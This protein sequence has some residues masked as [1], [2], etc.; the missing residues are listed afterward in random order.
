M[1]Q[2]VIICTG[3]RLRWT[4]DDGGRAQSRSRS[5]YSSYHRCR[6]SSPGAVSQTS[7]SY[8]GLIVILGCAHAGVINTIEY[9]RK[10]SGG[11]RI[12]AVLGGMHLLHASSRRLRL[13]VEALKTINPDF[14]G[15]A[16]CTGARATDELKAAFGKKCVDLNVGT[17]VSF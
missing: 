8:A 5:N 12:H 4:A 15:L 6:C 11:K 13:T 17:C 7:C 3:L 16:H 1:S 14:L 10:L 9:I 2:R